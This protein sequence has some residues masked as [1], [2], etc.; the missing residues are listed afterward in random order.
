MTQ[1]SFDP[2]NRRCWNILKTGGILTPKS[3]MFLSLVSS[4]WNDDLR[5]NIMNL[6]SIEPF[7]S[8]VKSFHLSVSSLHP[9]VASFRLDTIINAPI[10]LTCCFEIWKC[11]DFLIFYVSYLNKNV[12]FWLWFTKELTTTSYIF[13]TSQNYL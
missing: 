2:S 1:S 3:Y 7:L 6:S 9:R 4:A 5:V 10:I 12:G 11:H 13:Y 8:N